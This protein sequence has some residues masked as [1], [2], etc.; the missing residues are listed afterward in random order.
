MPSTKVDYTD[1]VEAL[2]NGDDSRVDSMLSL[3]VGRLEQY[4]CIV[5]SADEIDAKECV[6][7][8]FADVF[9]QVRQDKIKEPKFFFSYLLT[10]CRNE[11][12]RYMKRK[13]KFKYDDES[14]NL[15]VQPEEQ[16]ENLLE[17]ERTLILKQCL[18]E[19]QGDAKEFI[20]YFIDKP[21]THSEV[22][23]QKFN[24]TEA[25]VRTKKHRILA[26]LHHCYKRKSTQ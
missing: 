13:H 22:V 2:K 23:G 9:E 12:V 20:I 8:T 24:L 4:L 1:L 6:Q 15:R 19:L 21:D 25:N 10:S 18:D 3:I 17:K 5:M 26:R 11:Y 16:F 14:L 7:Q